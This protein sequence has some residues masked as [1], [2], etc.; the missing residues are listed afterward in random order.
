MQWV[1]IQTPSH[2]QLRCHHDQYLKHGPVVLVGEEK[3]KWLHKQTLGTWRNTRVTFST[4]GHGE[5]YGQVYIT[6]R[7]HGLVGGL[8]LSKVSSSSLY[9]GIMIFA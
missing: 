3:G 6:R 9:L 4:G 5:G 2:T 1:K 7:T 8:R